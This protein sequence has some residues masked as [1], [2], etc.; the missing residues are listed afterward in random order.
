M[1]LGGIL[2][3][4]WGG[5]RNRIKTLA[6]GLLLYAVSSIALGFAGLFW[7]FAAIVFLMCLAIPVVQT[8]VT[9]IIQE[10]VPPDMLGRTFS[11]M[12]VVFNGFIL[13][14]MLVFGPLA[15]VIPMGWLMIGTGLLLALLGLS[16]PFQKG[17][18]RLGEP[19]P[20]HDS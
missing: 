16:I 14:G 15:D 9:T 11:L 2:L 8:A 6:F 4:V 7:L 18:Y 20:T 13:L 12:S 19:E 3:G 17:F 5:F 10:K 1:V